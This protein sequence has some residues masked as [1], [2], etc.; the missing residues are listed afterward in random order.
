MAGLLHDV[1]KFLLA[2][3]APDEYTR[4]QK[5]CAQTGRAG[6]G[7][8]TGG[9]RRHARRT[10]RY[11]AAPLEPAGTHRS[12]RP[13]NHHNPDLADEGRLH[14]S[15]V[16]DAADRLANELNYSV[17]EGRELT[18]SRKARSRVFK[19]SGAAPEHSGRVRDGF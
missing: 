12:W 2:V 13:R 1:G 17:S 18:G 3:C 4:I 11:R 14:L 19:L 7:M 6:N 8:R 10:L 15:H 16:I 5:L 9:D